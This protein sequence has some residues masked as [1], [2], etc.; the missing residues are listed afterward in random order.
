[1][2]SHAIQ[3]NYYQGVVG[4]I[5][6]A[7][8]ACATITPPTDAFIAADTAMAIA[9]KD[10]AARYAPLEMQHA[11]EKLAA[12]RALAADDADKKQ[13]AQARQLADE[14]RADADLASAKARLVKA[15]AV[16]AALEKNNTNL[17][18]EAQRN[19]GE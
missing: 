19:T 10:E 7:L 9:N 5:L 15:Q 11:Q 3:N 6:V 1:M 17:R 8:V 18:N 2:K 16:N 14:A 4:V 13:M 12:A